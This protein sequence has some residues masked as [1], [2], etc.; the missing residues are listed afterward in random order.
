MSKNR[1]ISRA[2]LILGFLFLYIPIV[3]IVIYSFNA[4]KMV[5]VWGG[6]SLKWYIEFFEDSEM[7][8]A[9]KSS[10]YVAATSATISVF[11]GT[12]AGYAMARTNF[13]GKSIFMSL[14]PTSL[15][16]PEIVIGFS[17]LILFAAISRVTGLAATHG[18]FTII[19]AHS[20][21]GM[22]Y[23]SLVILGRLSDT[24]ASLEEAALDLGASPLK[25]FFTITIPIL[26]PAI[27]S[28]WLLAFTISLDD[29]VIASFTAGPGAT[30]LPMLVFSRLKFG[31]KPE[32]NVL[33]AIIITIVI[34][35]ALISYVLLIKK[36]KSSLQKNL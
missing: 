34:T 13:R 28:A 35:V 6:F 3:F 2:A 9:F 31:V 12:L 15:V 25:T 30:T 27:I 14:L 26:M 21:V 11:L 18:L 29:L 4:S 32:V 20:S 19:L 22:A 1:F 17:L 23:S 16:M 8:A 5:T 33:G 7:I 24:D 36:D 10:I